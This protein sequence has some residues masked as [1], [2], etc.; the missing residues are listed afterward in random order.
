MNARYTHHTSA[1]SIV[2]MV[3]SQTGNMSSTCKLVSRANSKPLSRPPE[4]DTLRRWEAGGGGTQGRALPQALQVTLI[5]A[6]AREPLL[7]INVKST[8]SKKSRS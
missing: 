5:R 8:C 6:H 4:S 2:V 7:W 3:W 1:S